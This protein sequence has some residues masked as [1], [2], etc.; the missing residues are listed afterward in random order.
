MHTE[1]EA[2]TKWCPFA[3]VT[4]GARKAG[5]VNL[6]GGAA[7][8]NRVAYPEGDGM[9]C[10]QTPMTKCL[11]SACMAWRSGIFDHQRNLALGDRTPNVGYCG[12]AGRLE[13]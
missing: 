3:R 7:T 12:L 6:M 2:K 13:V 9:A 5:A 4:T 11:G 1:D 8:F 10:D